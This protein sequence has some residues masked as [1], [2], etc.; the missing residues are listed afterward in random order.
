MSVRGDDDGTRWAARPT[1]ARGL[2]VAVF[3]APVAAAV[4]VSSV[5]H[6]VL[7]AAGSRVEQAWHLA[8]LVAISTATLVLVDRVARRALPLAT[9]LELSLLFPDRAPSRFS[10]ARDTVR[11]RTVEEQLTRVREA[12]ADP[13][14]AAREILG[15]VAALRAHDRPTRGHAERVRV[16]TDLVAEAMNVPARDRDLL[17]WAS[18]LHDI[19]KLR[20]SP[21]ILNKPGKP[22]EDEWAVLRAHPMHGAQI[23][24]ALL[25]WLGEWGDV[26]VQHHERYD[27]TGYPSGLAGR[28]IS[29]GG[30]I[31]AVADAY[32]VMTAARTYQRPVSR[33]AAQ[34]ELV[35]WSGQQFDPVVVRAM[36]GLSAPRLRR[37]QGVLAWL[38][39]VPMVATSY[40]PAATV[41]RVVGVG[42]LATGA[43]TGVGVPTAVLS[44][45]DFPTHS[46]HG[47]VSLVGS[48]S[49][50]SSVSSAGS[51]KAGGTD[52][53]A[54]ATSNKADH[55]VDLDGVADAPAAGTAVDTRAPS[56]SGR[57]TVD[58][59]TTVSSDAA[60]GKT[61]SS[62]R[63]SSSSGSPGS[64][65]PSNAPP[66][67]SSGSADNNK[68][69][70]AVGTA[71]SL[72]TALTST[73][74][75]VTG[76]VAAATSTVDTIVG[77]LTGAL[78]GAGSS[79]SGN[80]GSGSSGSGNSG[81]GN[82]GS[83][84]SGSGSSG[85]GNSG[86]GSSGSGNS[87]SGSS[88]SGS[89][90]S[91]SSGSGSSGS[92]NSGSG[93]SGS[94]NSGSGSSGSGN[95]G[96]G[97]SGSG[98]SGSGSSGSGS[99][100]SGSSG[101]GTV[102]GTVGTVT[103]TATDTVTGVVDDVGGLLGSGRKKK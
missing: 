10:V 15:L 64:D 101:S 70:T 96:S 40:V 95:S 6:L 92:G 98:S 2:R 30:R 37:A 18:L 89:S 16:L 57:P 69:S 31:V 100:G 47:S 84:S 91:G 35:K 49:S 72:G 32:E 52:G 44:A 80:S 42:A 14:V 23:A 83:G 27:G 81:S 1:L 11:N 4:G 45:A 77:T 99:S 39:D 102:A 75:A 25:P 66:K 50:V 29:L 55:G 20:V 63:A 9:L 28:E 68:S 17:R 3:A 13:A 7:G 78:G 26:I 74:T 21:T 71:T 12:G 24:R 48:V 73:A 5:A 61:G 67:S 65:T 46:N 51:T 36:V 41:A 79:G 86:S 43:A 22:T 94:G 58:V 87:G 53:D 103:G 8:V 59:P 19:G 62:D 85:S 97:S 88:G 90:G 82:S 33:I 76:T 93:S 38:S 56:P 54:G 34:R 60:R